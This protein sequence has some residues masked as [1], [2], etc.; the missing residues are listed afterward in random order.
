MGAAVL[1][2]YHHAVDRL[3]WKER[4][5]YRERAA[6]TTEEL[7]DESRKLIL[8]TRD[9]STQNDECE[10]LLFVSK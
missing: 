8:Y 6:E 5:V 7:E 10:L 4:K 9:L 1:F 2:W 3:V